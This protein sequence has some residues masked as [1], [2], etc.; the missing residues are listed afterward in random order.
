MV[1]FC[2]PTYLQF[3]TYRSNPYTSLDVAFFVT[4]EYDKLEK[5]LHLNLLYNVLVLILVFFYSTDT[6]QNLKVHKDA[7]D[8]YNLSYKEY[9]IENLKMVGT[10]I[11]RQVCVMPHAQI[12]Q[13][14]LPLPLAF[15]EYGIFNGTKI[16]RYK[17][18]SDWRNNWDRKSW[19]WR[20]LCLGI[21][22]TASARPFSLL[23]STGNRWGQT[24]PCDVAWR[25]P[26]QGLGAR[27]GCHLKWY[28]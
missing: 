19:S 17:Q 16:F 24:G 6:D 18:S 14:S 8:I 5:L 22:N 1:H 3:Y 10:Y 21:L 28:C 9:S 7:F 13:R 20:N 12:Y 4:I 2:C 25:I 23:M 11:A 15:P 26:S 27:V